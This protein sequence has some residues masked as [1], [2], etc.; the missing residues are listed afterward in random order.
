MK[1]S[2]FAS[3]KNLCILHGYVFVMCISVL[4]RDIRRTLKSFCFLVVGERECSSQR[5]VKIREYPVKP[6]RSGVVDYQ[7]IQFL[8][9][10]RITDCFRNASPVCLEPVRQ[11]HCTL[12]LIPTDLSKFWSKMIFL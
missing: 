11:I 2:I 7:Y 5:S 6:M 3:R 10:N 4:T 12:S 9:L 8:Y 1:F